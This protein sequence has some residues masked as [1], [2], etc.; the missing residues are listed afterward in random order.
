MLAD[1]SFSQFYGRR[2]IYLVSFGAFAL[3]GLPVAFANNPAVF[4]IFRFIT[5]FL[6]SAFLSVAGGTVAD[7]FQA[8]E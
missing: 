5:G 8:H 3:L 7:L 4:F 2:P 6:G 1:I